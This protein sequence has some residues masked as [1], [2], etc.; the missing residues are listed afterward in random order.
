MSEDPVSEKNLVEKIYAAFFKEAVS[1]DLIGIFFWLLLAIPAIYLPLLNST[2]VRGV[3]TFSILLFIPGYCL[4]AVLFPKEGDIDL[5]ERIALSVGLSVIIVS[6]GGFLFSVTPQG[7]RQDPLIISFVCLC[8]VMILAAQYQRVR[9]PPKDRFVFPFSAFT[10]SIREFSFSKDSTITARLTRIA[11]IAGII[12]AL[13]TIMYL[14]AVPREGEQFTGFYILGPNQTA[15]GYPTEVMDGTNY[16]VYLGIENHEHRS[17]RYT[18]ETCMVLAKA[19]ALNKTVFIQSLERIDYLSL[20]L[21]QNETVLLP[22]NLSTQKTGFNRV[23]FLLFNESVPGNDVTG[24]DRI[25]A[26]YRD[27]HLWVHFP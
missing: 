8:L 22:Y 1:A 23:E 24:S 15:T 25:N 14:V 6:M 2:P 5:I 21:A 13:V 16:P 19:D 4:A 10:R 27:L 11:L 26:S 18:L 7:I 9:L 20:T 12:L 3:F 17:V